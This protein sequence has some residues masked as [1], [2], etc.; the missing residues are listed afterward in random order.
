MGNILI[1]DEGSIGEFLLKS[2]TKEGHKVS[3]VKNVGEAIGYKKR[4]S[5]DLV[6]AGF[7]R[8][9]GNE[10]VVERIKNLLPNYKKINLIVK[11]NIT[12]VDLQAS[13]LEAEVT[14]QIHY[15]NSNEP[16]AFSKLKQK[17]EELYKT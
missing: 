6:I 10:E 1:I 12:E 5:I 4:D 9:N 11:T 13:L 3:L 16:T 15:I 7:T 14:T 17:V 2:L 8:K